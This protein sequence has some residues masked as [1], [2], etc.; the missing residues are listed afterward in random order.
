M[1]LLL[2][3]VLIAFFLI[4]P[5]IEVLRWIV[6]DVWHLYDELTLTDGCLI[7]LVVLQAAIL[8]QLIALQHQRARESSEDAT[9]RLPRPAAALSGPG[10]R[11][12]RPQPDSSDR[13]AQYHRRD[14]AQSTRRRRPR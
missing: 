8:L 2:L 4:V 5:G 10:T 14:T 13:A 7:I 3:A 11:R 12:R 1:L 9:Q 6:V